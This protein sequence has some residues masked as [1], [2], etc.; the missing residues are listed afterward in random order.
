MRVAG[1][2]PETAELKTG[3]EVAL[4]LNSRG[5]VT[6]V[7]MNPDQG[8]PGDVRGRVMEW[9]LEHRLYVL[10]ADEQGEEMRY[11]VDRQAELVYD[12]HSVAN[13]LVGST[14]RSQVSRS[15]GDVYCSRATF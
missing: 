10:I 7:L 13:C 4:R 9:D 8:E 11:R 12:S 14:V 2:D 3:K 1:E 15:S 5:Y 6:H